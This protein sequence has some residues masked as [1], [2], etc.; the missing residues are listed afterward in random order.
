M[1]FD[2]TAGIVRILL[3]PQKGTA[4]TGFVVNNEGLVATCAHVVEDAH[5]GPG[6]TASLIFYAA[7]EK[8]EQKAT[9]LKDYW[10]AS[11]A[12]DVALLRLENELPEKVKPLPLGR[13][14]DKRHFSTFGFPNVAPTDGRRG[15]GLVLG[16][17]EMKGFQRLQ[18]RSE[19]ITKGVSG[20]PVWDDDL[21]AVIGMVIGM[22]KGRSIEWGKAEIIIPTDP[23]GQFRHAAFATPTETL[24]QICADLR[25]ADQCPY[26]NLEAFTRNDA[27]FFFGRER[28]LDE[29]VESL[30]HESRFLAVLGPSGCGKSSLVQAGLLPLLEKEAVLGS[31]HWE[32]ITTRPTD[33]AFKNKITSLQQKQQHIGL[34]IDQFEELFVAY[35]E[36]QYQEMVTLL[37]ELLEGPPRRHLILTLRND[38][39]SRFVQFEALERWRKRGMVNVAPLLRRDE[40]RDIIQ[41]PA[42][43]AHLYFDEGLTEIVVNDTLAIHSSSGNRGSGAPNT[44]LPLLEFALTQLWERR[45]KDQGKL[46]LAAYRTIGGVI[47]GLKQWANEVYYA[48]SET[49][50]KLS[51]RIFT[52]LVYVNDE[53]LHIPDSRRRRS[54]DELIRGTKGEQRMVE[55][56]IQRLIT[57]RLLMP[58][59]DTHHE[60][61]EHNTEVT[62]EIIH[63]A[64]LREWNELRIWLNEDRRFLAWRQGIES[65]VAGWVKTA[66][67]D[68][69]LRDAGKLLR[70]G[71]LNEAEGL[72]AERLYDLNE[73]ERA[74]VEE[75]MA[76]REREEAEQEAQR[77]RELERAQELEQALT[78]ANKE[79][80][81]SESQRLAFASRSLSA[82]APET[83]LLLACEAVQR[84]HNPLSE[85]VLRDALDNVPWQVRA[86]AGHSKAVNNAV[87]SHDGQR[88]LT[89]SDDGTARLW[90]V[91]SNR[92]VIYRGHKDRVTSVDFSPDETQILTTSVDGTAR[93][94]R[95]DGQ[96][97]TTLNYP[98]DSKYHYR[99][100]GMFS[101]D[102]QHILV[103]TGDEAWLWDA[104][105]KLSPINWDARPR[106]DAYIETGLQAPS[107]DDNAYDR[108]ESEGHI[109]RIYSAV[110]SPDGQ[111]ILTASEDET[112]RVWDLSG[113]QLAILRGHEDQVISA[114]FSPPDGRLILTGSN[115][116]TARLWSDDGE[117]LVTLK[118]HTAD[119]R[120]LAFSPD[121]QLMLTAVDGG[122]E[123][124]VVVRLWDRSGKLLAT[125]GGHSD[126]EWI[127]QVALSPDGQSIL[128]ASSDKTARLWDL[129]G[130]TLAVFRGHLGTIWSATFSSNGQSILTASEDGTARLW[131]ATKSL[132]PLI[133]G[134]RGAIVSAVYNA[135]GTHI[136]TTSRDGTTRLWDTAGQRRAG[137]DGN[138]NLLTD[139]VL[140][141]DGR[142]LLT[143]EDNTGHVY[144]WQLPPNLGWFE[145]RADGDGNQSTADHV[146]QRRVQSDV[147]RGEL[148]TPLITFTIWE[149]AAKG[150][151]RFEKAVFSPDGMRILTL[152][153]ERSQLW[154][155]QGRLVAMLN[156]PNLNP[157]EKLTVDFALFSPDSQ[158]VL[159]GSIN[160]TVWVWTKDGQLIT[161]FLTDDKSA[162]DN[163]FSVTFSPDGQRILTTI[164]QSADLWDLNGRHLAALPCRANKVKRGLFS[165]SGDRILTVAEAAFPDVR[166][167]DGDGQ[168]ISVL[169]VIGG[170]FA[171]IQFDRQGKLL[172][173][174]DRNSAKLWD[175]NGSLL[176][177]L[178]T[179][180]ETRITQVTFSSDGEHL[181]LATSDGIA[182]LW[183]ISDGGT[184]QST[185]KG[186]TSE[187]NSAVF[188]PDGK[189]VLTA[190]SDGTAR[191]FLV[192]VDDLLIAA[193]RSVGRPLD[194]EEM[195]RFN[196]PTPLRFDPKALLGSPKTS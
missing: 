177:T 181:L 175:R 194:S 1:P 64:L 117:L 69:N 55:Q 21:E 125:L 108:A 188:S 94:W 182:Q 29:L 158:R 139:D 10:K 183:A 37:M 93:L 114:I 25:P 174:V 132:L 136:L 192:H 72:L 28:V 8:G 166:L 19:E 116:E 165:P 83:A 82:S 167:W 61:G 185:F 44:V 191:Q 104:D 159:G 65:R 179:D 35:P 13:F 17:L 113:Q 90:D 164:R 137:Y 22:G 67:H 143:A 154:D 170:E 34:V 68:V 109:G 38:F 20:A 106:L 169:S 171:P 96:S 66:P 161:P 14:L 160:G 190:S 193:A 91:T 151:L 118:G 9:V 41:K 43:V 112:A 7:K 53:T 51:R 30:R 57:A 78:R 23:Y 123:H 184:L 145:R 89:A 75:S 80:A 119:V 52:R 138:A 56:V 162:G 110:F 16:P 131:K 103:C 24:W 120:Q 130:R 111:R 50:R 74:F 15:E 133:E 140:S 48:L 128:T 71:D 40:I 115:D 31:N 152:A 105:G 157:R 32:I 81:V 77:Q 134:H 178:V 124:D 79:L 88:I 155:R 85:D 5:A 92:V 189:R 73:A 142:Y 2:F 156:G 144:L 58:R 146:T 18:L 127:K 86:F 76:L 149:D 97:I 39:Y 63:D 102:G 70:G 46:T 122:G 147:D 186:H 173:I 62:V 47:G 11:N 26:R 12:E 95:P 84:D 100:K 3:G 87:F 126:R 195:T 180:R 107:R 148:D 141:P 49:E 42:E 33:S 27:R 98:T 135:D 6:D 101:L 176:A 163:L 36:E 150:Y 60:A 54:K 172:C 121:G 153:D 45:D 129:E 196:I 4:G 187:V 168:L 59:P 99:A